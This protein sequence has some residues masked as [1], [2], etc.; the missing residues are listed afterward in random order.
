[1]SINLRVKEEDY[2]VLEDGS[3]VVRPWLRVSPYLK[4]KCREHLEF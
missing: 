1:M 2:F 3:G 4:N